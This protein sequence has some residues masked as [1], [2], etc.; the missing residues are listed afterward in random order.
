[1]LRRDQI[2]V[3]VRHLLNVDFKFLDETF[4]EEEILVENGDLI[5][6]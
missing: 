6:I 3:Q 1:M 4:R 5:F 2:C